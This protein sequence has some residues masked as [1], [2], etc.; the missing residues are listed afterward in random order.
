MGQTVVS[1]A[2]SGTVSDPPPI[3]KPECLQEE[4]KQNRID[5]NLEKLKSAWMGKP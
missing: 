5:Q 2:D 1:V 3:V 4:L